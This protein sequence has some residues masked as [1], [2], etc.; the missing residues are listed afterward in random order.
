MLL[1]CFFSLPPFRPSDAFLIPVQ[2]RITGNLGEEACPLP[3]QMQGPRYKLG[4]KVVAVTRGDRV[5]EKI[6]LAEDGWK[7]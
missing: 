1:G 3:S 6:S 5:W 7:S 4:H 2:P